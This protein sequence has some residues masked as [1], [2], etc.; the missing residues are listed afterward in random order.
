MNDT[1]AAYTAGVSFLARDR[2]FDVIVIGGG[3]AGLSAARRLKA[4]GVSVAVLEARDRIGGR[5]HTQ[6]LEAGPT[7][8][9]G[10]QFIGDAQRRISALVDEVGLTRVSPNMEGDNVFLLSPGVEPVLKQDDEVPLSW[11]GKLDAVVAMWGLDLRLQEF[12]AEKKHLDAMPASEFVRDLTFSREPS[13]FFAGYIEAEMCESLDEFSAYELLDQIGSTGGIEGEGNSAQWYLAEGTGPLAEHL[14]TGLGLALVCRAPVIKLTQHDE[15]VSAETAA[16]VYRARRL[17]VAVPPQLYASIGLLDLLPEA[18]RRVIGDFRPG[19]VI[20]TILVFGHPWWRNFGA[21]GRVMSAGSI[22]NAAVDCS[23]ADGS[24][25][26]LVLFS[27]ASSACRLGRMAEEHERIALAVNWL[28]TLTG[29]TVP[30]PLAARSIDWNADPHALGGYA[31]RRSMGG[32][33][34]VPDLFAPFNRVHFAGTETATEWRSFMEGAL[35]SAE[36]AAN[37][38]MVEIARGDK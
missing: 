25:G 30:K 9:L 35:Q 14:A 20:K 16:G 34:S 7:V 38:V 15:W 21:S 13:D 3:L 12:R 1:G 8:D 32:W 23:P 2:V 27:T 31:S 24:S 28:G 10:A 26:I 17:I 4:A 22:F 37:E 19:R 36:R 5:V 6:L 29:R 33:S 18:R 11:F